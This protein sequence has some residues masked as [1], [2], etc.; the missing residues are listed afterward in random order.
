MRDMGGIGER[1]VRNRG[2]RYVRQERYMRE[3]Y[4]ERGESSDM[5]EIPRSERGEREIE[6]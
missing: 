1:W 4:R 6:V 3:R 2:K 5:R